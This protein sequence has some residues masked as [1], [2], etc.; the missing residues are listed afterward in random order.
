MEYC[1]LGDLQRYLIEHTRL[2]ES[3]SRDIVGQ[4]VEGLK[5]MHDEGFAHRDL[6]PGNILIKSCPPGDDWWVK[7]CDMGLSK[8]IQGAGAGTTAVKGTHG[9]FAPEQLGLGGVDPKKADPFKTDIWC[10][11]EIAFRMLCGEAVFPSYNDLRG[12]HRGTVRFPKERLHE[13]GASSLAVAFIMSAMLVEPQSRLETHQ[14]LNH[15]WLE[16]SPDN[17]LTA[18]HTI[19]R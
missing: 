19:P 4:I 17:D 13:I 11:G 2:R 7:I 18:G 14:A 8:R 10:L 1:P 6:K 12:Y 5:F 9:F 3:D 15:E 16:M